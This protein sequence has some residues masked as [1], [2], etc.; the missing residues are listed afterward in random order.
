MFRMHSLTLPRPLLS[1]TFF[2]V[3][4]VKVDPETQNVWRGVHKIGVSPK[5]FALL[6][7]LL[8][9]RGRAMTREQLLSQLWENKNELRNAQTVDVHIAYLRRKLGKEIIETVPGRGY[10]IP[11]TMTVPSFGV[12]Q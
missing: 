5:E 8:K 6:Q 11:F 9:H 10:R 4:D 12:R 1:N 7:C 3:G 2:T